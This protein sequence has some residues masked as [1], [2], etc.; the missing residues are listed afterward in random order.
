MHKWIPCTPTHVLQ[1]W[2]QIWLSVCSQ[3]CKKEIGRVGRFS[4][5]TQQK[6]TRYSG[7]APSSLLSPKQ[8]LSYGS[9]LESHWEMPWK[10]P[11]STTHSKQTQEGFPGA[12]TDLPGHASLHYRALLVLLDCDS[13]RQLE[14]RPE[15][16][17]R[18]ITH[19]CTL[20]SL[21]CS[22]PR[23]ALCS[24][25]LGSLCRAGSWPFV[26][27]SEWKNED[28]V[29][30]KPPQGLTCPELLISQWFPN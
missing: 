11:S 8:N 9:S 17:C 26:I 13:Q 18:R 29:I 24:S 19:A 14:L 22:G 27:L 30:K 21:K 12:V 23:M 6:Q 28:R 20:L 7:R 25:P 2:P 5:S 1:V 10:A 16:Q 4:V 3:Q 15:K